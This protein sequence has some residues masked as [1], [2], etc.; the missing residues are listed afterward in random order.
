MVQVQEKQGE[1]MAETPAPLEFGL[2]RLFQVGAI[3]GIRQLVD[4]RLFFQVLTDLLQFLKAGFQASHSG[5]IVG[6]DQEGLIQ[7]KILL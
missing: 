7:F 4:P 3:V 1:G 2:Q 6:L 5:L